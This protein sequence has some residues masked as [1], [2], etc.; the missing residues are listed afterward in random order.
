[1]RLFENGKLQWAR[2]FG[3]S[4]E[5]PPPRDESVA[6]SDEQK[7]AERQRRVIDARRALDLEIQ[8]AER[9]RREEVP[10][11]RAAAAKA[12]ADVARIRKELDVAETKFSDA[13][14]AASNLDL[15]LGGQI[16]RARIELARTAWP[17][18]FVA[19]DAAQERLDRFKSYE[20][21][22]LQ[23]WRT[24]KVSV[25]PDPSDPDNRRMRAFGECYRMDRVATN[26]AALDAVRADMD[27]A[28]TAL[29][30]LP[31]R[32]EEP[33][34]EEVQALLAAFEN[35]VWWKAAEQLVWKEP[36][37]PKYDASGNRIAA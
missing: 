6:V 34:D 37:A 4:G 8:Q 5:G 30:A 22:Q 27:K 9:R 21:G 1:M 25:P 24:E 33:T 31:W 2:L 23:T 12:E 14:C 20:R 3:F 36:A 7:T 32:V 17:W 26:D 29:R 35:A 15:S 18:L 13:G 28:L 10:A 19:I 16:D 11:L